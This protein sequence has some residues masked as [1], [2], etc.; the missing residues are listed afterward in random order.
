MVTR[1][2][3]R[4][5]DEFRDEVLRTDRA[6]FAALAEH[7]RG[8][9]LPLKACVFGSADALAAANEA[10]AVDP[11]QHWP[12]RVP[13]HRHCRPR[14]RRAEEPLDPDIEARLKALRGETS[15][16]V[17]SGGGAAGRGAAGSGAAHR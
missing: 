13:A 5:V 11:Y 3:T 7:M 15:S 14:Q 12:L 8:T 4:E 2:G 17:H 6:S 1:A 9:G 10:T 16:D